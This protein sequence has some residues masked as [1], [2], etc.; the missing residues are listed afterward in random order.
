MFTR[1][2]DYEAGW[3]DGYR[4]GWYRARMGHPSAIPA[5]P[6]PKHGFGLRMHGFDA[7][8]VQGE[9]DGKNWDDVAEMNRQAVAD[10]K[11]DSLTGRIPNWLYH[12]WPVLAAIGVLAWW[13]FG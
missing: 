7:G 9:A 6:T 13:G 4:L 1:Q 8:I 10:E 5:A 12:N 3:A 11:H 2:T